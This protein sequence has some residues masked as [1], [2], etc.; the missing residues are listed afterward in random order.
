[1][2]HWVANV[3]SSSSLS[4][5][6]YGGSDGLYSVLLSVSVH[7]SSRK[8]TAVVFATEGAE[9]NN[10]QTL[11]GVVFELFEEMKKELD[12][13]PNVPQVSLA[14]QNYIDESKAAVNE[15]INKFL[16]FYWSCLFGFAWIWILMISFS[17][18]FL[19]F[20]VLSM[21]STMC[22]TFIMPR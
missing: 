7:R 4:L 17:F 12:L 11:T 16:Y 15:Q 8:S 22:C 13:V 6:P 5:F 2:V 3:S 20:L 1:M 14:R 9:S 19:M 10:N 18:F 21:W